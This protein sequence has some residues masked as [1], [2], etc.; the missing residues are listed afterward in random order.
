[1]AFIGLCFFLNGCY[2]P[3]YNNFRTDHRTVRTAA[4]G[5]AIGTTAGLVSGYIVPG[6]AIGT[7][8]GTAIGLY[9]D[10]KRGLL[11]ELRRESIEYVEYGSTMTLIVPTDKYYE[12]GEPTLNDLQFKGLNAIN[13]LLKHYPKSPIYV[14]AF[15]DDVGA[16]G[17]KRNL[18]QGRA[19]SMLTFL[20]GNGF[21]SAQLFSQGY[22]DDY[23]IGDNILIHGSAF[24]R[25]VEIQFFKCNIAGNSPAVQFFAT[26]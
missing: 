25:R 22:G 13:K 21:K 26:K 5:A 20:W 24:N 11:E 12:F 19:E 6:L 18:T 14:A 16:R 9:K 23:P 4:T 1:V 15:S 2:K 8:T 7:I 17:N 3:P 10:S